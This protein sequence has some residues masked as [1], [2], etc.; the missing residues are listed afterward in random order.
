[1]H[2]DVGQN[3]DE[4]Q[5]AIVLPLQYEKGGL[6]K[7]PITFAMPLHE[8][9]SEYPDVMACT[10]T[11][12]SEEGFQLNMSRVHPCALTWG[13]HMRCHVIYLPR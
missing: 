7:A 5:D 4:D 12:V 11:A 3:R 6:D 1:M 10:V 9:G 8:K 2:I 13:Q